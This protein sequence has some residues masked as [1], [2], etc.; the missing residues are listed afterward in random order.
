MRDLWVESKIILSFIHYRSDSSFADCVNS[1]VTSE[2]RGIVLLILMCE[3]A[4]SDDF[5]RQQS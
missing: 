2:L 1:D 5:F 3:D 4:Y